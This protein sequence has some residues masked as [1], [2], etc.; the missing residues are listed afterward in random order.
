MSLKAAHEFSIPD[1]IQALNETISVEWSKL[2][3]TPLHPGVPVAP[4]RS[5][6][7]AP[8]SIYPSELWQNLT[9]EFPDQASRSQGTEYL[10]V[11]PDFVEHGAAC[12]QITAGAPLPYRR[13][14]T[15]G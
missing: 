1:I 9:T 13:I 5:E 15:T 11:Y 3:K 14:S 6:V 2:L 7:R 4:V 12:E 8:W 10:K